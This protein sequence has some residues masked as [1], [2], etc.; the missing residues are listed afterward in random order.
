MDEGNPKGKQRGVLTKAVTAMLH[1][2]A[3]LPQGP[4]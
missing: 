4:F 1:Q 2:E 3:R